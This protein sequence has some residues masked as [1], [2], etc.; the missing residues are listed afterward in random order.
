MNERLTEFFLESKQLVEDRFPTHLE[1]LQAPKTLKEAMMYSLRAG[2]KRIRPVLLLAT[3]DSYGKSITNGIDVACALE[4]IHTYSLI[5]DDLPAMDDDDV[6]RGEPTNHKVF[7]EA[8]AILA[9][10]ALLTFAFE[11]ITKADIGEPSSEKKLLL[12]QE[13]AK[14]SGP[15]GMVG[16]QMADL[17]GENKSLTID[18]LIYIHHHKTGDLFTAAIVCGAIISG[19]DQSDVLSLKKF[20]RELG[21]LFQIRDDLLDVEGDA[22]TIGKPIGSDDGNN[23]STY[24]SLLGLDGAKQKLAEH[25][26]R[27]KEY[28]AEVNISHDLLLALTDYVADR[29]H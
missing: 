11:L 18:E 8:A 4:M 12:I 22:Y 10:D 20:A 7:G 15:E 23:K 14:A 9:G 6:R 26:E 3:L 19:A 27:A 25:K 5:H 2:G 17:E 1:E 29:D 21:L 13:I 24:P 28:L 16:G